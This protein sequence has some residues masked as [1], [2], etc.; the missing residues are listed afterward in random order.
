MTS[1]QAFCGFWARAL[2][3]SR[4]AAHGLP[5]VWRL[6]ARERG[7]VWASDSAAKQEQSK[8]E[9]G[10]PRNCNIT[11]AG[12]FRSSP[13]ITEFK[14]PE[15]VRARTGSVDGALSCVYLW[16]EQMA[17]KMLRNVEIRGVHAARNGPSP[18]P[19]PAGGP[20]GQAGAEHGG[21]PWFK[22]ESSPAGWR[23][24][25]R[26]WGDERD[27]SLSHREAVSFKVDWGVAFFRAEYRG[28]EPHPVVDGKAN[29]LGQSLLDRCHLRARVEEPRYR[30]GP[31]GLEATGL[32]GLLV[33]GTYPDPDVDDGPV[34][35]EG[36]LQAW[37]RLRAPRWADRPRARRRRSAEPGRARPRSAGSLPAALRN[38]RGR[39]RRRPSP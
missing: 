14:Q 30:Q 18:P 31:R 17:R 38:D 37:H 16:P 22:E 28:S 5:L 34:P 27:G 6:V 4:R 24:L 26:A 1:P 10:S 15:T 11:T 25:L 39:R 36:C 32:Q 13:R 29:P 9:A 3:R 8:T 23:E 12:R 7:A 21:P 20:G 2:E 19:T 35:A 33:F